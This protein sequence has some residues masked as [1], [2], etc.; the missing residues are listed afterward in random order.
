MA[1]LVTTPHKNLPDSQAHG[2]VRWPVANE[3]E[4]LALELTALDV[5]RV[6]RQADDGSLWL[7]TAA[8]ST[9]Q[10]IDGT[11]GEGEGLELASSAPANVGTAAAVGVGTTA[12]RAD[13]VHAHGVHTAP[14]LHA[15][16]TSSA[17]G[18]LSAADKVTYDGH[19]AAIATKADG[20]AMAALLA[21]KADLVA[22]ATALA[23]KASASDVTANTA[24]I[25]TKADAAATTAALAL[26]ADTSA[27]T[28]ALADKADAAATTAALALKAD[29]AATTAALALKAAASD[30]ASNTAAIGA[31]TTAI[32]TKADAAA[33]TAALALKADAAA[34]TAALASKAAAATLVNAGGGLTGGGSL[35][36][37]RTLAVGANADGSIIVNPDDVQIGI[38]ASDA[39]HGVRGGGTQH[40]VATSGAPGF[41]SAADKVKL[42]LLSPY[43]WETDEIFIAR[44]AVGTNLVPFGIGVTYAGSGSAGTSALANDGGG[45]LSAR[46]RCMRSTTATA[47]LIAELYSL[48]RFLWSVPGF[49]YV[50]DFGFNAQTN[51]RMFAGLYN[52]ISA[53][54][55]VAIDSLLD[56]I[57][58]G[59]L[60]GNPNMHLFH[61]DAS[62]ACTT[63]DLGAN[64]PITG[65]NNLYRLTL[66][67]APAAASCT[68]LVERLQTA[69]SASGTIT[70]NLPSQYTNFGDRLYAT[71]NADAN[72]V[73]VMFGRMTAIMRPTF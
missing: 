44:P 65:A 51:W 67:M 1:E 60:D 18:F 53:L 22:T 21:E 3:A 58:V 29:A 71:N 40:A 52:S 32:A 19:T 62:G 11:G 61:N 46:P 73:S 16:A 41:M 25:A 24:A 14:G 4:R 27:M 59:K 56:C 15:V 68:Y 39:Q 37:D 64:L 54:T 48:G 23:S 47:G 31:N 20:A 45:A 34:T 43:G 26:K 12:A 33:T 50:K 42:D 5:H 6:A 10:R 63:I 7:L 28:A 9:W 36:A 38:L 55:N 69:F 49:R 66:V 2:V 35:A 70:T 13:H 72:V 8:P 57:G 17:A 30:V